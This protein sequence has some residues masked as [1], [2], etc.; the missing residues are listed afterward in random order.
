MLKKIVFIVFCLIPFWLH[1]QYDAP[2]RIELE[3]AKDQN[4]YH[5]LATD[6]SGLFIFYEGNN[7]STDTTSWV[8]IQYD[9]NFQKITHFVL[10]MPALTE[11]IASSKSEH[12]A[13]FLFQKRFPKKDPIH[14]L[15]LTID[16]RKGSYN[17][18]EIYELDNNKL[19]KIYAIDNQIA[20]CAR[21][22]KQD[23]L[24]FYDF[25]QNKYTEISN[26]LDYRVEFCEA[27]TAHH[28]W[29]AGLNEVRSNNS[30]TIYTYYFDYQKNIS[31]TRTLPSTKEI[32]YNSARAVI[33]N[34]DSILIMGTYNT[35]QDKYS[36]SLH[37]GV[38]TIIWNDSSLATPRFFSYS[39]LK[40]DEARTQHLNNKAQN[41]NLNLQLLIAQ[42]AQGDNQYSLITEV[43]YPEYNY[44]YNSYDSYGY[45]YGYYDFNNNYPTH[46]FAGY[47]FVNA[48]ITTFDKDG[49]L[50]WDNFF[51]FSNTLT[52]SLRTHLQIHYLDHEALVL[53][54][55]NNHIVNTL[56]DRGKT[57]VKMSAFPIETSSNREIVEYNRNT[58]IEHWYNNNFL[59]SG[60][61]YLY[62]KGKR[63]Q[64][65]YVFFI[66]KVQYW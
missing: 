56:L 57:I 35:I 27:D 52:Q 34:K 38:Y 18:R 41:A 36:Y 8:F 44:N 12:F 28:R 16:L 55:K 13:Y 17:F 37:S 32:T 60:Y 46:T 2:V 63:N 39:S 26:G 47:R 50:L 58:A 23:R 19:T 61:Q 25:F 7:I 3:T 15:L 45:G 9:T 10:P 6:T 11:F 65:K 62:N 29:L 42:P 40:S 33:I 5:F 48:Y 51:P 1:A 21:E 20:I 14:T 22:D 53:Y 59:I 49:N 54:P 24:Y 30:G 43:F 4:D 64:K 31:N 66:N